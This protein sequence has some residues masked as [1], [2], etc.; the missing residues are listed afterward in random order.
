MEN[1]VPG[2]RSTGMES[3]LN[4]TI[5]LKIANRR[6]ARSPAGDDRVGR[7]SPHAT[8]LDPAWASETTSSAVQN[9]SLKTEAHS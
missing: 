8:S 7:Y 6:P 1:V 9:D 3:R 4:A 2:W 5:T